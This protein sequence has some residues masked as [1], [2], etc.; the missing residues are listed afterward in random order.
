MNTVFNLHTVYT[1]TRIS[2]NRSD[3][4][5]DARLTLKNIY[6]EEG[7]VFFC[8]VLRCCAQTEFV[9]QNVTDSRSGLVEDD[10]LLQSILPWLSK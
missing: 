7:C 2:G 5:K 10:S 8:S 3:L 4:N 1:K 6:K 9:V